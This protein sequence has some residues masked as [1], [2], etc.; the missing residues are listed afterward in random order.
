[1]IFFLVYMTEY[2]DEILE[3]NRKLGFRDSSRY[4]RLELKDYQKET[5]SK[6]FEEEF[7]SERKDMERTSNI[8]IKAKVR[9]AFNFQR[10]LY[11]FGLLQGD[12]VNWALLRYD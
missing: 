12:G 11:A 7:K 8:I 2:L 1:M 5:E 3:L 6:K 9:G 4:F 10:I